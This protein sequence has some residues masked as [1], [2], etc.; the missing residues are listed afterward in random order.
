LLLSGGEMQDLMEDKAFKQVIVLKVEVLNC[1]KI[2]SQRATR[3]A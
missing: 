1:S 2:C 3:E